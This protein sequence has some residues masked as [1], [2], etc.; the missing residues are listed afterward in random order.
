MPDVPNHASPELIHR[1]IKHAVIRS[2]SKMLAGTECKIVPGENELVISIPQAP[3]HGRIH[4]EY[5]TGVVTLLRGEL[6]PC[7]VLKGYEA[8]E[9]ENTTHVGADLLK[10]ILRGGLP[11]AP[12]ITRGTGEGEADK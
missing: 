3:Q 7:G 5:Q 1:I 6:A 9:N 2:V 4:I 8:N 11:P 12:P 10:E